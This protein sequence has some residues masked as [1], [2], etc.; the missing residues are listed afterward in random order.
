MSAGEKLQ[1]H[2]ARLVSAN[3][4]TS[5]VELELTEGRNREVRRLFESQDLTVRRLQR[6]QIGRDKIGRIARGQMA[7]V[8]INRRLNLYLDGMKKKTWLIS[9]VAALT[10]A[11]ALAQESAPADFPIRG[12]TSRKKARTAS[13][14]KR[15][16]M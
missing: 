9:A 16:K 1:A 14:K 12:E 4:S 11:A 7:G 8:D 15:V 2:R 13:V 5:V 10:A 3:N 6:I